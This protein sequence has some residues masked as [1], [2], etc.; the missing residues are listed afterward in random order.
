MMMMMM[1][2]T[3]TPDQVICTRVECS[4]L[5][6]ACTHGVFHTPVNNCT[7]EPCSVEM[8]KNNGSYGFCVSA[9]EFAVQN[10]VE[11]RNKSAD[12]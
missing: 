7:V 2:P 8:K 3:I 12:G 10:Q 5:P 1:I 11:E 9:F 4:Y 6:S